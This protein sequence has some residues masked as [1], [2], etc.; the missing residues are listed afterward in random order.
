MRHLIDTYIEADEPKKISPFDN[1][2]L[3]ELITKLGMEKV[4]SDRLKG[5]KGNEDAIAETIENNVR[6][7]IIKKHLND[8]AYFE[9]MSTLL[10]EIIETRREK[11][12]EYAEYLRRVAELA[13]KVQEGH[14]DDTPEVLKNSSAMRAVYNNLKTD[15]SVSEGANKDGIYVDPALDLAQKIDETVKSSRPDAWRGIQTREQVIKKA[16]FDVLK[17]VDA[18]EKIFPIIKAQREY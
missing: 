4:L 10:K 14:E 11:K 16:L 5:L 17:D 13:K 15:E 3:L 2:G 18:V 12:I 6:S 1:M 8:P 9:K 7:K